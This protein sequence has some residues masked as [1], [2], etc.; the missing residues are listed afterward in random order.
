MATK[1]EIRDRLRGLLD[2]VVATLSYFNATPTGVTL[3]GIALSLVG[4][5]V[6]ARG[7]LRWGAVILIVSG[8]CDTVDGSLARRMGTSSTFGAFIDSTG[9]RLTE[10]AYFGALIFYFMGEGAGAHLIVFFLLVA[11]AGSFL[12]SYTRARAEGL[13]LECTVGLLE[14]PERVAILLGG[15]LF[16]R[17]LLVVVVVFLAISTVY[18]SVQRVMHVRRL[19]IDRNS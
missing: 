16:G 4:A 9:D 10:M 12:T 5:V 7:S 13:G 8:L 3:F 1:S 11:L 6:V 17:T 19:T 18:T 2:P 14:R 15:L